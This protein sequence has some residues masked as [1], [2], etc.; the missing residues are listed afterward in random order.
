MVRKNR[1]S[2]GLVGCFVLCSLS[3]AWTEEA[4]PNF[5][6]FLTDDQSGFGTSHEMMSRVP[7]GALWEVGFPPYVGNNSPLTCA[8]TSNSKCP[9]SLI[10]GIC[11]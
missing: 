10:L 2:A 1:M 4:R 8:A 5:I 6:Q 3:S 9:A 7:G 11:N